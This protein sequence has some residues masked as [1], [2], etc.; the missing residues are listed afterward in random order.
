MKLHFLGTGGY[1][2]NERRH[3]ACLMIPEVGLVLDAG[4]GAFRIPSLLQTRELDIYL[5]HAHLDHIVGL[6]YLLVP[7]IDGRLDRA[8]VFGT[9]RVLDAIRTHLFSEPVFPV[10]P[11]N[12]ELI[13]IEKRR[14]LEVGGRVTIEHKSLPSHPGGS[15]AYRV[16]WKKGRGSRSFAYV[17]D[18]SV[19]GSYN[20][21]IDK[22]PLLIHECYFGDE[23]ANIALRTGHSTTSQVATLARAVR[24]KRL[25]LVHVDPCTDSDDP[26]GIQH[27]IDHFPNSQIATDLLEIDLNSKDWTN[28]STM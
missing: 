10:F 1:Q 23:K 28:S 26:I 27:A 18:T 14:K 22:V 5:T 6:T 12:M 17:T 4:T 25:L 3:T 8:R 2:P 13:D 9:R 24:A 19:D 21:F 20:K 16:S 7:L 11:D 15:R